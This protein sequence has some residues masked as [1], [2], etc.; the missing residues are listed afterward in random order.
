MKFIKSVLLALAFMASLIPVGAGQIATADKDNPFFSPYKT[1]LNTPPFSMIKTEHFLPAIKEG[2][3]RQQAEID[4]LVNN[5][6]AP[7][8]A[9]TLTPFDAGGQLLSEVNGVFGA[10][11]GADTT[12]VIQAVAKEAAP[13]MAAHNDNIRLNEKLF[14]RIKAVYDTRAKLKLT[15]VEQFLLENTYR[16]FVRGGAL[17]DEKRKAGSGS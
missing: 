4:V 2:I 3:R 16:D 10:L 6:A 7:T 8:F 13:L 14:S 12:P 9:N 17:L 1:P 11:Q 5:P 15:P